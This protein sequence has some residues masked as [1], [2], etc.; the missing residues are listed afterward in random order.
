MKTILRIFVYI[1][2]EIIILPFSIVL[3]V[4]YLIMDL[5]D[6]LQ[7]KEWRFDITKGFIKGIKKTI[8]YVGKY[9]KTGEM[10]D[11]TSIVEEELES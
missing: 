8:P 5:L 6:S 1:V 9:F 4:F 7:I 2:I 3:A 11:L 10:K